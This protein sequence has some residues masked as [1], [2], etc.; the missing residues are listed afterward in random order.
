ML[1]NA[2]SISLAINEGV[3][4]VNRRLYLHGEID[5][6]EIGM[7]QR[8][9][10]TLA[11]QSDEPIDLWV[12]SIG[13][14]VD[15]AFGLVDIMQLVDVPIHTVAWGK[16][17]S[18]APMLVAAGKPG[19]RLS[20]KNTWWMLHPMRAGLD[21]ASSLDIRTYGE[22]MEQSMQRYVELLAE[23]S[24]MPKRHWSNLMRSRTD[25]YFSAQDA[26]DWG[27]VDHVV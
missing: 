21:E 22:I 25:R 12:S 15:E 9:M 23:H 24:M 14:D 4:P 16:V 7:I 2:A 5:E 18:A 27:L 11:A 10:L 20:T 8:G 1:D 19:M 3:D 26:E 17:M 13:G 6:S